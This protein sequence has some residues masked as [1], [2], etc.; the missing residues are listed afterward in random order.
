MKWGKFLMA[1][2]SINSSRPN[3]RRFRK[4]K[5]SKNTLV[6]ASR[7]TPAMAQSEAS[8]ARLSVTD[9]LEFVSKV[10]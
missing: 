7:R 10:A 2:Y 5:K 3:A 8:I 9:G 1:P 6:I 4:T